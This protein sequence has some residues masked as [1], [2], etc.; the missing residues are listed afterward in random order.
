MSENK[1][2]PW[3]RYYEPEVPAALEYPRATMPDLVEK[4]AVDFPERN[5]IVFA[6]VEITYRMLVGMMHKFAAALHGLGVRK[7]DRVALMSPNSPHYAVAYLAAQKTGAVVVQVNPMYVERELEHILNDAGC[8]VIIAYDALYPRIKSIRESTPLEHVLLFSLGKPA[9]TADDCALPAEQLLEQNPPAPPAVDIDPVEDLAVL[10]YTGG[11]TGVSKGAML[12]HRNI[13]ANAL[14][15][16]SWFTGCRYGQERVLS[17]LPFFHVYGMT[18]AMNFALTI[19]ATQIILPR[20][21]IN[22]VLETINTHR[23]TLFPGVPTMYVAINNYPE[24]GRYDLR[25]INYCISGSAPLPVDVAEKFEQLT[26]GYLV[27]GYGLTETSPVTHCNPL[28]GR[29]K[30]GSIGL[31]VPDTLCKIVDLET[32]E[33]E[34][35]PGE[36]GE[37]CINGPQVMKGYWNMPEE[38]ACSLRDG[39]VYT[40]DVAKMDEDGYFYIVE[41]KKDMIIAGGY[42]IYPREVEEV[43]F[44][45][46]KV[47]EA[48]V[49]GV[50]DRYRGETVKAYV[51][52]KK[53]QTACEEELIQYCRGRLAAYKAPRQVEFRDS[54]PKTIV[55]KVLR[56]YLRDEEAA[57]ARQD[58]GENK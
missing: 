57:A 31:P 20:F 19:A 54:L 14:Q 43:L 24:I 50:P 29:R 10:Q 28:K 2:R 58:D 6:G 42:N 52:L 9:G 27:E 35:P 12:T 7:G 33:Q 38:T 16:V 23:P 45:H 51:V 55:G 30:V 17:V 21:E 47:M 36:V 13:V 11:T 18:V 25:S 8:R 56:R 26:G 39:W 41:R 34:L 3:L 46:P 53:G 1:E 15:V 49:A 22:Q 5:A 48:V 40:G 4:A 44:E 32:G 37:L